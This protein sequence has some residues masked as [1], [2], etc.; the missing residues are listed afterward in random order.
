MP[1]ELREVEIDEMWH[2]VDSKKQIMDMES[3]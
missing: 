1:E 2:F 3:L